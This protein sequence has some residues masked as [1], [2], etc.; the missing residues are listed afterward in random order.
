MKTHNHFPAVMKTAAAVL[1]VATI[2]LAGIHLRTANRIVL[3]AAISCGTA[4]YHFA[5]RLLVGALVPPINGKSRWF[6]PQP[7]E[8]PLYRF[9][10]VKNWKKRLP[11]YDPRQFSLK[12]NT[13]Q[14]VV[15][16]MC[17]A[18]VVHEIIML[19]SFLPLLAVPLF[20]EFW[21]FFITSLL[22]ALFDSL[23]VMAQ[24]YNRPRLERIAQKQMRTI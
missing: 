8:A 17:G 23:F 2:V 7:W 3:A 20:G 19:C 4:C 15:R 10:G 1:A 24:R 21:V 9:L 14:Q 11:T 5:M 6:R 22:S 18:E 13:A 16:N 12:E